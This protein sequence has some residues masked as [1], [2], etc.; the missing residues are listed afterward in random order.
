[1][2][3]DYL[4]YDSPELL[5]PSKDQPT[6]SFRSIIMNKLLEER[7]FSAP[8]SPPSPVTET[9]SRAR[10][11]IQNKLEQNKQIRSKYP[12]EDSV[13]YSYS[14]NTD[15]SQLNSGRNEPSITKSKEP[16]FEK[17]SN[18]YESYIKSP[19][20]CEKYD[21]AIKPSKAIQRTPT[22]K[23]IIPAP[24]KRPSSA[25]ARR[26]TREQMI[27][28]K[29][30]QLRK[31]CPFKPTINKLPANKSLNYHEKSDNL[32]LEDKIERWS[33]SRSEIQDQREKLK[34]ELEEQ[35]RVT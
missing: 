14:P 3:I 10:A 13:S 29:E 12:T 16:D 21:T 4:N 8:L 30:E 20:P 26:K 2:Q 34:R 23:N 27:Q 7:R 18:I 9:L 15:Y 24:S 22:K 5:S 33:K 11:N 28:E 32:T 25:P 35:V 6:G 31:E 1:M 17:L 19:R